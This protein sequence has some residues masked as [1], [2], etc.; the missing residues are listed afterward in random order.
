[1]II[2]VFYCIHTQQHNVV[3]KADC[4]LPVI[5]ALFFFF[6]FSIEHK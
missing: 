5:I 6:S 3:K 4:N 1:M 2:V